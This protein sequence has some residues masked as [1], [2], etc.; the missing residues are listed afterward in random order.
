MKY[1]CGDKVDQ[2]LL[3][4]ISASLCLPLHR[5]NLLCTRAL[6][7]P[8]SL[9]GHVLV[10]SPGLSKKRLIKAFLSGAQYIIEGEPK[11]THTFFLK[12]PQCLRASTS[13]FSFS[14][15]L[16]YQHNIP[17]AL[18]KFLCYKNQKIQD[19][20]NK[21]M[22]LL[23]LQELYSNSVLHGNFGI[24]DLQWSSYEGL[25]RLEKKITTCLNIKSLASKRVVTLIDMRQ[26]YISIEIRDQG[27]WIPNQEGTKK[28]I[29][30]HGQN[31]IKFCTQHYKIHKDFQM[32]TFAL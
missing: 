30:L 15:T 10:V 6:D 9:Q 13:F 19:Q 5:D 25:E 23:T 12:P 28:D 20:I 27:Q 29:L 8:V 31:L 21:D 11:G 26:S 17:E 32:V 3:E 16:I 4:K 22:F 14:S 1:V 18:W 7:F 24:Q 2:R